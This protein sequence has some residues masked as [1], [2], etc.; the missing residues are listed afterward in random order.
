MISLLFMTLTFITAQYFH[1][2]G[3]VGMATGSGVQA[4]DP[5]ASALRETALEKMGPDQSRCQ[6]P[7][8]PGNVRQ[9]GSCCII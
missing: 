2:E 4:I 3:Y 8:T 7:G 1:Q 6:G 9:D 5:A